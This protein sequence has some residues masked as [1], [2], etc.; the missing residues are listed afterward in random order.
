M[1]TTMKKGA[2]RRQDVSKVV[3]SLAKAR[4]EVARSTGL[5][6]EAEE[7]GPEPSVCPLVWREVF[8]A[9]Y[10]GGALDDLEEVDDERAAG[11]ARAVHRLM[12]DSP[13]FQALQ[14]ECSGSGGLAALAT[15]R[16]VQA[17]IDSGDLPEIAPDA[18][19][20][21]ALDELQEWLDSGSSE[22]EGLA[23]AVAAG[24][25]AASQDVSNATGA[26]AGA[27]AG[28]SP[29]ELEAGDPTAQE[30]VMAAGS[31]HSRS[32]AA[33]LFALLG[34]ARARLSK[35]SAR[36]LVHEG[37]APSGVTQGRDVGRLLSTE[38]AALVSDDTFRSTLA[39]KRLAEGQ[40]FMYETNEMR[41]GEL[42]PFVVC[43]DASGSMCGP[44]WMEGR[45]FA[46]AAILEAVETGRDVRLVMFNGG[47]WS[48]DLELDTAAGVMRSV[49]KVASMRASGGTSFMNAILEAM[50]PAK[51]CGALEGADVLLI[52]DGDDS[53]ERADAARL[54]GDSEL[55]VLG[56]GPG[57]SEERLSF[58]FAGVAA[59]CVHAASF[60]DEAAAAAAAASLGK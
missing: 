34:A 45:A 55:T 13:A 43:L 38:K 19:E 18:T 10:N 42:G 22:G 9:L 11:F 12:E 47:A 26:F 56:V 30:A 25:A 37:T 49:K 40:A 36:A 28:K 4:Y 32:E 6:D 2:L 17:L 31:I 29:A 41:P 53:L 1:K 21:E 24:A 8:G 20:E 46:L 51:G 39:L 54:L 16:L 52:T 58:T 27:F 57:A 50:V 23:K 15:R 7:S 14:L 59:R 5:L 60:T 35:A 3:G 48:L 33:D 44:P